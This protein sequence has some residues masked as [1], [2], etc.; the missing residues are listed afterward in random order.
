MYS[1][2]LFEREF[3]LEDIIS[4]S[5]SL[6]TVA[7]VPQQTPLTHFAKRGN[8]ISLSIQNFERLISVERLIKK[9]KNGYLKGSKMDR[10]GP[11]RGLGVRRILKPQTREVTPVR[12]STIYTRRIQ[13]LN[14]YYHLIKFTFNY[15]YNLLIDDLTANNHN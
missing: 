15:D 10:A 1:T 3:L 5:L 7:G 9:V 8:F 12:R 13:L 2:F 14:V 4:K 6:S 11:K